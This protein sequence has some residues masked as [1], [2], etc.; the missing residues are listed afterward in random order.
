MG[1]QGKWCDRML[2]KKVFSGRK[3]EN[4]ITFRD[5]KK[6]AN[7]VHIGSHNK[8]YWTVTSVLIFMMIMMTLKKL[9]LLIIPR[10]VTKQNQE[11]KENQKRRIQIRWSEP[12][13]QQ[14]KRKWWCIWHNYIQT[15][16]KLMTET[17]RLTKY[18]LLMKDIRHLDHEHQE[19]KR[20]TCWFRK[21]GILNTT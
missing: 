4:M 8:C 5:L 19:G 7:R 17:A 6:E 10:E 15:W 11:E 2:L 21:S 20:S 3:M 13:D 9:K 16:I 1:Y 14:N 18:L 12:K